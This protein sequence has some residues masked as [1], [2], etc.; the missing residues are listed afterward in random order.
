MTDEYHQNGSVAP[1]TGPSRNGTYDRAP[2]SGPSRGYSQ[3]SQAPPTGPS[4]SAHNRG[5][6]GMGA[7][8]TRPRGDFAS[9]PMRG[10]G[11][12]TY[13][14]PSAPRS[15]SYS[16]AP[17]SGPRA[18]GFSRGDFGGGRGDYGG[19][20]RGGFG[21]GADGAFPFRGSNNSTSTTYPRTQ[22][23]NTVQ[24]HL[25]TTEKIVPGGKALPSGLTPEQERKLKQLEAESEKIRVE[26]A[27]KQKVKREA[28]NEWESRERESEREA[29][30]SELAEQSL[31][32]L[33]EGEDT[34]MAAF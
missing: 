31:Q 6:P 9:P 17:P 26:L 28:V 18:G 33:M 23:F 32:T 7:A 20:F 12:L 19:G 25:N 13:R 22:R 30:R 29:L 1:P 21:R 15:T 10:R 8:P 4:M 24:Q 11:S 2:P 14:A 3:S 5:G 27:E 34:G 16:D